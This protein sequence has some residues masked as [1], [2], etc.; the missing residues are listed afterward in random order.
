MNGTNSTKWQDATIIALRFLIGW[1]FLYEGFFKLTH[2]EWSSIAYLSQSDWIFSGIADWIT[3]NAGVLNTVDFLNTWGLLLIGLGLILGLLTRAAAVAG[4]GL[5]LL[6]YL[7]NPPFIGLNTGPGL[8]GN[9]L[10]VNKTL[11]EA[12]A[13]LLLAVAPAAKKY[14]LDSI[15]F[16]NKG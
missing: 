2:P 7:F 1:H 13:M 4:T 3:S 8:E 14:G 15:I 6:Y 12:A 9:Y 16:R 10:V 11:I 5:L